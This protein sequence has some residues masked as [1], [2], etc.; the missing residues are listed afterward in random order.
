[1]NHHCDLMDL[2]EEA[3]CEGRQ[4]DDPSVIEALV[5]NAE[6][7]YSHPSTAFAFKYFAMG[8]S[9]VDPTDPR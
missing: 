2:F 5:R 8:F 4:A 7:Q 9:T 1:M 6:G 3:F